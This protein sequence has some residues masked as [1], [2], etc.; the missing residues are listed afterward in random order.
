MSPKRRGIWHRAIIICSQSWSKIL[1]ATEFKEDRDCVNGCDT[2]AA[3]TDICKGNA[4]PLQ[5]RTGP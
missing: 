3:D 2:M 4:I 1:V 5:A